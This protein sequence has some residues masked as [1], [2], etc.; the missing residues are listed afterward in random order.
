MPGGDRTGPTGSGPMT[1]RR[2]GFCVGND[3]PGTY[4]GRGYRMHRGPGMGFRHGLRGWFGR[5]YDWDG[6]APGYIGE[7]GNEK[8]FLEREIEDVKEHLS[9]LEN[10]LS[11]IKD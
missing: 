7:T 3:E 6:P 8:K 2:M 10:K 11:K 9:F 1:G 4:Y 5:R